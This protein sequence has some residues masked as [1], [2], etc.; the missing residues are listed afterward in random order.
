M[1]VLARTLFCAS[2]WKL[3]INNYALQKQEETNRGDQVDEGVYNGATLF[4]EEVF[5]QPSD[6]ELL[7]L[8]FVAETQLQND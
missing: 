2:E 3:I 1:L 8:K 4:G 6:Q 7:K 5:V